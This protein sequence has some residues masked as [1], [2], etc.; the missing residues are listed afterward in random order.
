MAVTNVTY[1]ALVERAEIL[2]RN[3]IRCKTHFERIYK[4]SD[5]PAIVEGECSAAISALNIIL[6]DS[7]T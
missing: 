1:T 2:E 6:Q 3:L 5:K 4:A 7:A